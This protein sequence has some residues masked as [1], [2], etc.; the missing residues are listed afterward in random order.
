MKGGP[1]WTASWSRRGFAALAGV[2]SY[3]YF[4]VDASVRDRE[5]GRVRADGTPARRAPRGR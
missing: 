2:S 3:I 4:L 5:N 1:V